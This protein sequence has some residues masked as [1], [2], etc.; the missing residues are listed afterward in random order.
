MSSDIT[1]YRADFY[2]AVSVVSF[3]MDSEPASDPDGDPAPVRLQ[4][5]IIRD[6]GVEVIRWVRPEL[7][8][9]ID[10]IA[11]IDP[12]ETQDCI[13]VFSMSPD[14]ELLKPP[15][16]S[17][18]KRIEAFSVNERGGVKQGCFFDVKTSF[19]HSVLDIPISDNVVLERLCYDLDLHYTLFSNSGKHTGRRKHL[20][21]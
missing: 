17:G 20:S 4:A 12:A 18:I 13:C 14:G 3:R 5:A 21:A 9:Y 8:D 1:Q 2:D 7:V 6:N 19:V 10:A 11:I 16:S 15:F